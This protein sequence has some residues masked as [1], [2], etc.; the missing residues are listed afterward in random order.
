M[1]AV[2]DYFL[3][4]YNEINEVIC[5]ILLKYG[6]NFNDILRTGTSNGIVILGGKEKVPDI[7][8]INSGINFIEYLIVNYNKTILYYAKVEIYENIM[9]LLKEWCNNENKMSCMFCEKDKN[10]IIKNIINNITNILKK[11]NFDFEDI[12]TKE[13]NIFYSNYFKSVCCMINEND[14]KIFI[15]Y[16]EYLIIKKEE[17]K[18][19]LI[20]K[21]LYLGLCA[22]IID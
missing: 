8:D 4:L 7:D 1:G 9:A 15:D 19:S 16:I 18:L 5:S 17:Y 2:K 13:L 22:K 11:Y 6:Y 14:L 3:D 12:Q 10:D 20:N 21:E